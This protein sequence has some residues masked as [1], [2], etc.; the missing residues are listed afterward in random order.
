[1]RAG[2]RENRARREPQSL[3]T[4]STYD[5]YDPSASAAFSTAS[6]A[7]DW[8]KHLSIRAIVCTVLSI[9]SANTFAATIKA[10]SEL[11][12]LA[13]LVMAKVGA[14]DLDGAFKAIQP[15][16]V[17]A[18]SEFQSAVLSSKAQ[19]ERYGARY[20]KAVGYECID[21]KKVGE[22]L[23]K[24]LCI[25]KTERHAL[26]WSFYFYRSPKGWVLNSF[27]WNDQLP[28]IFNVQP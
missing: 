1:M 24:I 7:I 19:R 15:F 3:G 9:V 18:D 28:A 27:N 10:E 25:E 5:R 20:G 17:I 22:S 2:G 21:Q 13:E 26:P 12:P 16:A 8:E 4:R 14:N 6:S 11:R 23:V